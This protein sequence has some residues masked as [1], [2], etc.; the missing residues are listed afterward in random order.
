MCVCWRGSRAMPVPTMVP[1]DKRLHSGPTGAVRCGAHWRWGGCVC[2]CGRLDI[3]FR[4]SFPNSW[5]GRRGATNT[6]TGESGLSAVITVETPARTVRVRVARIYIY[7]TEC[8][9]RQRLGNINS[10][11]KQFVFAAANDHREMRSCTPGLPQTYTRFVI[12]TI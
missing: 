8:I 4:L 12:K 2:V 7:N 5:R 1:R 6:P 11:T 3:A 9:R 10:A